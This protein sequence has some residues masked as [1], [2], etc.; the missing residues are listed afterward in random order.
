MKTYFVLVISAALCAST[1]AASELPLADAEQRAIAGDMSLARIAAMADA[2]AEGAIADGALPDPEIVIGIQNLPVRS[3]SMNDD[4]MSMSMVGVR[5]QFPPGRTRMLARARSEIM[6][7]AQLSDLTHRELEIRRAVRM[8]W[9]D[10]RLAH[11]SLAIARAAEHEFRY[12][13]EVTE[14]RFATGA[15]QQRDVSQAR[16]ELAGLSERILNLSLN[17]DASAARLARWLDRPIGPEEYPG[18]GPT[19]PAPNLEQITSVLPAHPALTA[20][21]QRVQA[22]QISTDIARQAYR[23]MWMAEAGYGLRSGNR[24]D[25][26]SVMVSV[27][28]PL[29]TTDR[30]D[31]RLAAAQRTQDAA[32]YG[33]ADRTREL[34][35]MLNEQFARWQRLSEMLDLYRT[36]LVPDAVAVRTDTFTAYRNNRASFDELARAHLAELSVRTRELVV[37]RQRDDTH[38]ELM[39]LSGERP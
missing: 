33:H 17:A 7:I 19:W 24:S 22:S 1:L 38:I 3:F 39:F 5:Q 26:V 16:L 36:H 10:W 20:S 34:S 27:S 29:F 23:P 9:L 37:A 14:Q 25:M 15:S 8:A 18:A 2:T 12:L 13:L 4:M 11:E 21:E 30:Q 6:S 31:R 28:V 35:G 32:R